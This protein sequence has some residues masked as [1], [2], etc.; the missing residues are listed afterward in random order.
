MTTIPNIMDQENR[1]TTETFIPC[2]KCGSEGFIKLTGVYAD[3]YNLLRQQPARLNG[4]ELAI[5]AGCEPTAMNNR[6]VWLEAHGLA[7]R[8]RKGREC[9]WQ[10]LD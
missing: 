5:L 6:L 7:E 8:E 9:V 2:S 3:T 4:V 1:P 10:A